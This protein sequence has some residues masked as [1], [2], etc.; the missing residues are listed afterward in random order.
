MYKSDMI[1]VNLHE[2]VWVITV[3]GNSGRK[4]LKANQS[5]LFSEAGAYQRK[6]P[7]GF[8]IVVIL[9]MYV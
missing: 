9:N 7:R 5:G 3:T 4:L 8:A 2:M 1:S 6:C